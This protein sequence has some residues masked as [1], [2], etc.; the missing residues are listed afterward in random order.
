IDLIIDSLEQILNKEA[1]FV[2]VGS[3]VEGYHH[4]LSQLA[5]KYP[6][7]MA[8]EFGYNDPLAHKIIAGCDIFLMPSRF[9][10]C[11]I[12]QM[13]A[14]HYGTVPVVHFTGGLADTVIPWDGK[15]GNG[16]AFGTY[17]IDS[18]L[19]AVFEAMLAYNN[20]AEWSRIIRNGMATDFSWERAASGYLDLYR[21]LQEPK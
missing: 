4:D 17:Q 1:G 6:D 11:G 12:T 8:V 15:N 20:P 21:R 14:L 2:L 7:R 3:G 18:M 16:F 19:K 10:P 5:A 13:Y 9:E